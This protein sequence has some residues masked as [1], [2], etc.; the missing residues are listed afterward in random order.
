MLSDL[1][2]FINYFIF[3]FVP[4]CCFFALFY[5]SLSIF[6]IILPQLITFI[7]VPNFLN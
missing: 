7:S 2:N 1:F 3:Y 6:Y 4:Y 5:F